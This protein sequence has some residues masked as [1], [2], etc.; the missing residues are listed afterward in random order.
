M[1]GDS[2][3]VGVKLVERQSGISPE[4]HRERNGDEEE[5]EE[6]EEGVSGEMERANASE[7]LKIVRLI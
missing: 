3:V 6:E 5:R 1:A 2:G 4:G 7:G